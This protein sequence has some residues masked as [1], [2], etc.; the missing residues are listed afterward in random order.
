M[1]GGFKKHQ[2]LHQ[3]PIVLHD[4]LH[5]FQQGRGAEM[6]VTEDKMEQQLAGIVHV[7]LFQVFID[8]RKAYD[9]LDRGRC[10]EI[11]RGYGLGPNLLW[12]L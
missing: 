9:S 5:G 1:E 8:V 6:A 12:I 3:R 11:V 4:E 10:M 2:L 7:P